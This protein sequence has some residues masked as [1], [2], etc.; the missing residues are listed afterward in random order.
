MWLI[1][2]SG[3]TEGFVRWKKS[4]AKL[5]GGRNPARG[6]KLVGGSNPAG[7]RN[8]TRRRNLAVA[9]ISPERGISLVAEGNGRTPSAASNPA[10]GINLAGGTTHVP[11]S[12]LDVA[13]NPARLTNLTDGH[14]PSLAGGRNFA[15]ATK[16]MGKE[17]AARN[18]AGGRI[19]LMRGI[20][21]GA[22]TWQER[23]IWLRAE[24]RLERESC[25]WRTSSWGQESGCRQK[26][27]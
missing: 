4:G 18:L 14:N 11:T 26:T 23:E 5:A 19:L 12:N 13:R 22:E 8:A 21:L 3:M 7:R 25:W 10:W 2:K 1:A 15:G 24:I 20:W 6:R 27:G 9:E 17:F 16:W